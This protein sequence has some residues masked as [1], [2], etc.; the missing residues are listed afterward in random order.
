M[1]LN[2]KQ[3]VFDNFQPGIVSQTRNV[4]SQLLAQPGIA[5]ESGTYRC[6]ALP[7]GALAPL[8]RASSSLSIPSPAAGAFGS[9]FVVTGLEAVG[10][11]YSASSYV[12]LPDELH[13][14][15]E[16]GD[17]AG[18][19]PSRFSWYAIRSHDANTVQLATD[20]S[21]AAAGG[22]RTHPFFLART[23]LKSTSAARANETIA[24][25]WLSEDGGKHLWFWPN[26]TNP[27]STTPVS[28]STTKAGPILSHDGSIILFEFKSNT[29]GTGVSISNEFVHHTA[30]PLTS[31]LGDQGMVFTPN[32]P[33][34]YGAWISTARGELFLVK[35]RGGAAVVSGELTTPNPSVGIIPFVPS[36]GLLLQQAIGTELGIIYCSTE[37]VYLWDGQLATNISPQLADGFFLRGNPSVSVFAPRLYNHQYLQYASWGDWA[38]FPNNYLFDTN[39]KGWW[40]LEDPTVAS[41]Q[42]F[43]SSS[44]PTA[45]WATTG[46]YAPLA[47]NQLARF[48][49]T[50]PASTYSW[51]SHPI[52]VSSDRYVD[53]RE[54]E[55]IAIAASGTTSSVTIEL[56]NTDGTTRSETFILTQS[57]QPMRIRKT[58]YAK[59]YNVIMKILSASNQVGVAAPVVL[60]VS[61]GYHDS[62]TTAAT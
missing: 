45:I 60:S 29:R 5:Q 43:T 39:G 58:T 32:N 21:L 12:S 38:I 9:L 52:T 2:L 13:V 46:S 62:H 22:G 14:G 24:A 17:S 19:N 10:Q 23:R 51:L 28:S 50:L 42:V 59:G 6:I 53:I 37:S 26:P 7:T 18:S 47:T 44:D 35:P 41:Y 34:G 40:K 56:T 54:V 49:T 61:L 15:I 8:P 27:S 55:I 20:S 48:T 36:T 11:V 57:N 31:Q 1:A 30:P 33:S 4:S 25:S 16:W 3:L